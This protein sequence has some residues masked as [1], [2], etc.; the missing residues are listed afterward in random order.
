VRLLTR[1]ARSMLKYEV[2]PEDVVDMDSRAIRPLRPANVRV[3]GLP[4]GPIDGIG[5]PNFDVSW[6]ERNRLTDIN[7]PMAWAD[8]TSVADETG[9][10]TVIEVLDSDKIVVR[11]QTVPGGTTTYSVPIG[12][13]TDPIG[14]IRVGSERD[15]YRE[16]Q[17]YAIEV[18]T[19][20]IDFLTLDADELTL[21]GESLYFA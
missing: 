8:A 14:W 9:Q 11:T 10:D 13:F 20:E 16:W 21:G 4:I 19:E 1:T 6:A 5:L 2:A 7:T 12:W 3:E 18:Y 17:G 15:G